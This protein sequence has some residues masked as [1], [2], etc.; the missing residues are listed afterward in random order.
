MASMS[1]LEKYN[2]NFI[3]YADREF[4]ADLPNQTLHFTSIQ[5]LDLSLNCKV[6]IIPSETTY[7]EIFAENSDDITCYQEENRL[8]LNQR[9]TSGSNVN[10]NG[11]FINIS[12]NN[13]S[14][15]NGRIFVDGKEINP[16]DPTEQKKPIQ[17]IVHISHRVDLIANLSGLSVLASKVVF[18]KSKIKISGSSTI[19]IATVS[20]NLKL[21]GQGNSYCVMKGGD[22]DLKISGQG[23][24]RIKGDW[25]DTEASVS[26]MG[27]II[28]EGNCNGDYDASV[29]GMGKISHIGTIAG[30]KRKSSTGMG[31]ISI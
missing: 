21:S 1:N 27:Q 23:T 30:C 4:T 28:T 8:I 3:D 13:T 25:N 20:L 12:G 7:V 6:A 17:V 5:V 14:I 19:G 22:V 15:V 16:A 26:G 2:G 11:N 9:E 31:S 29:S 24:L 18:K 10:I